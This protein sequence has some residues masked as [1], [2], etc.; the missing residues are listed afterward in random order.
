MRRTILWTIGIPYMILLLVSLLITGL[1]FSSTLRQSHESLWASRLEAEA[2]MIADQVQPYLLLKDGAAVEALVLRYARQEEVRVTV[3]DVG[4]VVLGESDVDP[5]AMENHRA[6]HEVQQA[7]KD[8]VGVDKRYSKTLKTDFL[9]VA[10]PMHEDGQVVG[11]T[12]LAVSLSELQNELAALRLNLFLVILATG[13]LGALIAVLV[14][15]RTVKPL[16]QL[17][18]TTRQINTGQM[19]LSEI[20][21]SPDE[22]GQLGQAV[23]QMA[24][25]LDSQ[26]KTLQAERGKLSA[27]LAQMTDGVLI[28]DG[29]G[30]IILLNPAA[31]QL[32]QIKK[33]AAIGRSVVEVLRHHQLVESWRV[34]LQT[35]EVQS[36]TVETGAG[37]LFWQGVAIPLGEDLPGHTLLLIQD[38]TRLRRLEMVRRDF[39]SNV[40]HELRTPL[41]AIGALTETL[42]QAIEDPPIAQRFLGRMETEIDTMTQLVQELLELSRIESGQVPLK[43]QAISPLDLLS[44]PL[45]RM[46]LQVERAGLSLTVSCPDNLPPVMA[47]EERMGQVLVNLLHNAVKFTEPGGSITVSARQEGNQI[48]FA[49]VDTGV[50]IAPDDLSRIFE[51]FY[52]A[53]RARTGGG[54][55]LG[56][57]IAR[58]LVEAHGGRIWAESALGKGSTF[59]FSLPKAA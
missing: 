28:A 56:L 24:L 43:L 9:Y 49:V 36:T 13:L 27:V 53:D 26:I 39:I 25:Q 44:Q 10:V 1:F 51:R 58:H 20:P 29:A 31:E 38:L 48:I 17:A 54:T 52:K 2:K 47:D 16:R 59:Y 18:E 46:R 50:G 34:S 55:G 22:V 35:G 5:A 15:N 4:G 21:L 6:R 7:L 40:S 3:I 14:T 45:E 23:R 37:K 19:H 41:A 30:H 57:S 32:F 12:R 11:V 8:S 33:E 42:Q